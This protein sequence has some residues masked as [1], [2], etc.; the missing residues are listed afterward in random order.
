LED[1]QKSSA[2]SIGLV[3]ALMTRKR[4]LSPLSNQVRTNSSIE[5]A[6]ELDLSSHG[7]AAS[8]PFSSNFTSGGDAASTSF[9]SSDPATTAA[10]NDV[11]EEKELHRSLVS[12]IFDA[13]VLIAS[14]AEIAKQM[15][16]LL[17]Y[18]HLKTENIKSHLQCFRKNIGTGKT[19]FMEDYDRF[20]ERLYV[21][22]RHNTIPGAFGMVDLRQVLGGKSAALMTYSVME[23]SRNGRTNND[24]TSQLGGNNHNPTSKAV[25]TV[26]QSLPM[27]DILDYTFVHTKS[28]TSGINVTKLP[29][30]RLTQKEMETPVGKSF[31]QLFGL[32]KDMDRYILQTRGI[33]TTTSPRRPASNPSMVSVETYRQQQIGQSAL[34]SRC[35]SKKSETKRPLSLSCHNHAHRKHQDHH[36][37]RHDKSRPRRRNRNLEKLCRLVTMMTRKRKRRVKLQKRNT[38]VTFSLSERRHQDNVD[39]GSSSGSSCNSSSSS[40]SIQGRIIPGRQANLDDST[41]SNKSIRS[42]AQRSIDSPISTIE[43]EWIFEDIPKPENLQ[44]GMFLNMD[45][46][47]SSLSTDDEEDPLENNGSTDENTAAQPV[48]VEQRATIQRMQSCSDASAIGR[49]DETL[50]AD[51]DGSFSN[52]EREMSYCGCQLPIPEERQYSGLDSPSH[53]AMVTCLETNALIGNS[54]VASLEMESKW[55]DFSGLSRSASPQ[56]PTYQD[57]LLIRPQVLSQESYPVAGC[58]AAYTGHSI[59][60]YPSGSLT[61]HATPIAEPPTLADFEP[62]PLATHLPLLQESTLLQHLMQQQRLQHPLNPQLPPTLYPGIHDVLLGTQSMFEPPRPQHQRSSVVSSNSIPTPY[63]TPNDLA[64]FHPPPLPQLLHQPLMAGFNSMNANINVSSSTSVPVYFSGLPPEQPGQHLYLEE[65]YLHR[66]SS[67]SSELGRFYPVDTW[68]DVDDGGKD[69]NIGKHTT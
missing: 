18:P 33:P 68:S 42:P 62:T 7:D 52:V 20:L 11:I 65:S 49:D 9:T 13:G 22:H 44:R 66:S 4:P 32:L 19:K 61:V 51:D 15:H 26:R 37:H 59:V 29:V 24:G 30:P 58:T 69:N 8:S 16:L 60:Q 63:I 10:S 54:D 28:S 64:G 34:S 38:R 43:S 3:A 35:A 47:S 5:R 41:L 2:Q 14:P 46:S 48:A 6:A 23:G 25:T 27:G 55:T 39:D 1:L 56:Q 12:A 45:S 21:V 40:S 36:H 50:F 57:E 31:L 53:A 67:S 17:Q